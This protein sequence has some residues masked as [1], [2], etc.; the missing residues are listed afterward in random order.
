MRQ[1]TD[2]ALEPQSRC[3]SW[4]HALQR[5]SETFVSRQSS[6]AAAQRV[7]TASTVKLRAVSVSGPTRARR[8]DCPEGRFL[9]RKTRA[10]LFAQI[11]RW[12]DVPLVRI[13]QRARSVS[14]LLF[15][16]MPAKTEKPYI[17]K[18]K[19]MIL[20]MKNSKRNL[21]VAESL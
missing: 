21:K 3:S 4:W 1:A 9:P 16:Y 12:Q 20:P 10:N 2:L 5:P 6:R 13:V 15:R 7:G 18:E 14:L 11:A 19:L 8:L 17:Q